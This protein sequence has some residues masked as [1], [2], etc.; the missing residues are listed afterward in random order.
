V[1]RP[2]PARA[3]LV[4]P[5]FLL[6]VASG[7][8]YF[9]ALAMLQPVLP[10]YV[11]G[12]LGGGGVGVGVA[13][14][15]LAVGAVLLRPFAGRLGDRRGRRLLIVGGAGVV[16]V[17]TALY[18]V[19]RTLPFIVAMRTLS[20]VGEA[21]FFVGAATMITDLAPEE[22]RGEAVSYWSVAVYG[23]VAFGPVL[24][25]VVLG[26]D[27]YVA[28]WLA[29]AA[30]AG[31]A[32]GLVFF[33]RA[34]ARAA[35]AGPD[36]GRAPIVHRA[37]VAPGI[38]L[39]LGLVS[40]AG[41]V[42]FVPLYVTDIGWRDAGPV[43]LLYGLLI[44]AVRVVGARIP[45][46]LGSVRA[47]TASLSAVAVGMAV[48]TIWRSPAGLLVGTVVFAVGMSLHYPALMLMALVGV[49]ESERGSVV[50]TFSSFF[51]LSQGAGALLAGAAVA[52]TGANAAAFGTGAVAAVAGL[53][54][55]RGTGTVRGR[56]VAGRVDE[57]AIDQAV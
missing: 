10:R 54:V 25:E 50:G 47:A 5:R 4:T 19:V 9:L 37:A 55:L 22:R 14:G 2:A 1:N 26:D 41:F 24:G 28:A 15:A 38:I 16:A 21:A 48:A 20:G 8:C 11:E 27:R 17:T 51:D 7:L 6:V 32:C 45:D 52:I 13:V 49:D 57:P 23:G 31:L 46:R 29:S 42:A 56:D 18:G 36:R 39:F 40:L 3:A 33:P 30:L 12:P 53:V 43:F 35:P 44:L 34:A